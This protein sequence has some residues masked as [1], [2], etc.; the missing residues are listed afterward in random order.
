[1]GTCWT[2]SFRLYYS[3]EGFCQRNAALAGT[4]IPL[5]R[6]PCQRDFTP[7]LN[8]G[9]HPQFVAG[10]SQCITNRRT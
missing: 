7:R 5:Q 1:M 3:Q 10:V 2:S 4:G 6:S 9:F 8:D